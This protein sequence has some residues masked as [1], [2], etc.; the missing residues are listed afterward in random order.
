MVKAR[1]NSSI[2]LRRSKRIAAKQGKQ[3]KPVRLR[4]RLKRNII[5]EGWQ[6]AAKTEAENNSHVL[7]SPV[8]HP[9]DI[10]TTASTT[11][12]P[13]L[14]SLDQPST[15][16]PLEFTTTN[17]VTTVKLSCLIHVDATHSTSHPTKSRLKQAESHPK[18]GTITTKEITTRPTSPTPISTQVKRTKPSPTRQVSERTLA[19]RLYFEDS[20]CL[21]SQPLPI[22]PRRPKPSLIYRAFISIWNATCKMANALDPQQTEPTEPSTHSITTSWSPQNPYWP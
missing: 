17:R 9:Q 21:L 13:P 10:M 5:S 15:R 6:Q 7:I 8:F 22:L 4:R 19:S 16:S 14:K 18:P 11:L 3:K 1:P 12:T 2:R 20:T